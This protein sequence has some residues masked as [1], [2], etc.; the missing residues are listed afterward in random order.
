MH[1]MNIINIKDNSNKLFFIG[2]IVRDEFLGR[3]SFDIDITYVGNA[4]EYCSQFGE[5][6]QVNPDFGTVRVKIAPINPLPNFSLSPSDKGEILPSHK[7]RGQLIVD[8]A[9]TRSE[10]YPRKGHLPV[11]DKIGCSLKEDVMRRDFTIN[12]LA[13]SVTTGEIVDYTGGLEDLKNKKLRVL[14][15]ESFIDDP[16]R[17][18]RGLKFSVRFGFDLDEHTRKLQE[19]YLAN[20]NYDMSYKRVK[21]ELIETFNHRFSPSSAFQASSPTIGEKGIYQLAFEKFINEKI[22]KLVTP[23][24][25]EL[26]SV[27]IEKLINKY[28]PENIWLIYVGVLGDL[29]RL[30]LTKIEQK[31]LDDVPASVL[32]TDFELY[33]AFENAQVES[34]L[35]YGILKDEQG[36][37]HYLDDLRKIKISI[38]GD[39]LQKLG[40]NPS[41][42]YQEIFDEILKQKLKNPHMTKE[43]EI[44]I[45]NHLFV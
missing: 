23:N 10:S 35:L 42:K 36:A 21:K 17:I 11:V 12:A 27:N 37:R 38:N 15:D 9:S 19:D 14:H 32:K 34:V 22:Y 20:I 41:P 33:K 8:F 2:G 6:V 45:I 3:E 25:V 28:E 30:P 7:E 16:T 29:S 1:Y 40:I 5:V 44:S 31:I 13:K 18:I 39:D 43:D 4:I 24:E 26:P